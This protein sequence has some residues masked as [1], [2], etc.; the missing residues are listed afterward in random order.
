MPKS[1]LTIH[2]YSDSD[3][4]YL[5]AAIEINEGFLHHC[6]VAQVVMENPEYGFQVILHDEASI[7]S[8]SKYKYS[9]SDL[10]ETVKR[11]IYLL[12]TKLPKEIAE[13][14]LTS[15]GIT[16]EDVNG[17]LKQNSVNKV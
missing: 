12:S 1:V 16:L 13:R 11:A 2:F 17:Y 3:Y 5:T 15:E 8:N 14:A 7:G 6:D 10:A 4:E 9:A